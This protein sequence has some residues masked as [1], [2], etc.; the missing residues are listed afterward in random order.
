MAAKIQTL[1][2]VTCG[3]KARVPGAWERGKAKIEILLTPLGARYS[4][5]CP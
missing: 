3:R 1:T 4:R 5:S 2:P